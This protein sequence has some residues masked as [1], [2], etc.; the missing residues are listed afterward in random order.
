MR[1]WT[2]GK[3]LYSV[4]GALVG[5][6]LLSAGT[7]VFEASTIQQSAIATRGAVTRFGQLADLELRAEHLLFLEK[8]AITA[9]YSNELDDFTARLKDVT[10]TLD[11]MATLS[12][13]VMAALATDDD[14]RE[15]REFDAGMQRWRVV[16]T[17][18]ARLAEEGRPEDA[19]AL[20]KSKGRPAMTANVQH[21]AAIAQRVEDQVDAAQ[22]GDLAKISVL[23]YTTFGALAVAFLVGN[24]AGHIARTTTSGLRSLASGLSLA[25]SEV[26]EAAVQVATSAQSLSRGAT[27]QAA[28]LEETSASMEE[29]GAMTRQNAEHAREAASLMA[30]VERTVRQ[31][32]AALT[33]M[34]GSMASIQESS[35]KVSRIIRTIDEIAFQTN[36]LALNAAVE[37]ARAGDA[38]QGFAVVADEVRNLAQRSARA[39][40]DTAQL[41][42][43]SGANAARGGQM[44]EQ[45]ATA[46]GDITGG[47]STVKG[48]IDQ[49]S[50]A[51]EQQ[52]QG[53]DQVRHAITD[54]EQVTQRT[55]ATAEESAAASETLSAQAE[56]SMTHV[57]GLERLVGRSRESG[58]EAR[59]RGAARALS[60]VRAFGRR[61]SGGHGDAGP[62]DV[63]A[64]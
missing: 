42:E 29:M 27:Q 38:G 14:R 50:L 4:I 13:A 56:Q 18:V 43:E 1:P 46:I 41:I 64:A 59:G 9:A 63:E 6:F 40:R 25:S 8:D 26:T 48:L 17:E 54:M 11:E 53:I 31:S 24:L 39:A 28:S 16:F 51:S 3:K 55:A 5:L 12:P 35:A 15:L 49:V 57:R 33:G 32:N 19:Q 7:V 45:V 10:R 2:I 58:N 44:V 30:S 23:R 34:V 47:V 60:A 22:A 62:G 21:L 36:I 52:A 37:A 61:R 20:S